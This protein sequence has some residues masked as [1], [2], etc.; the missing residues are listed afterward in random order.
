[1]TTLPDGDVT[2]VIADERSSDDS[3]TALIDL[4]RLRRLAEQVLVAESAT[5]E[6]TLTFIDA[7]EI[8]ALNAEYMGKAGPTDVLS[9]PMD[10]DPTPGVPTLL[11]DI[12]VSPAV[13]FEQFAEHA[14]TFDDEIALL[15]VHGVL[16]VLGY[17]HAEPDE[18]AVM[19]RREL[20]VLEAHHWG[21]P[22]PVGF[23]QV[24]D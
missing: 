16:H 7:S 15:V 12:V 1:V 20:D 2:V 10:D 4:D 11:G 21:G 3:P 14:G 8:A 18:A 9:F 6:L 5:G 19:R 24:H 23:R 17:D 13:A 22:A